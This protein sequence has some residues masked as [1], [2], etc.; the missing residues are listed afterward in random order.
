MPPY[1]L[2][3]VPQ[4]N[5][6]Y[7]NQWHEAA[8]MVLRRLMETLIIELYSR[9]GWRRDIQDTDTN[10]FLPLK[11]LINKLNGDAR[12][13]MQKRTIE[14]L[15]KVKELGDTAAHDFKIRIRKSDLDKIQSAVR[16]TC[17]RLIFTIGE[18]APTA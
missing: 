8:A 7:E 4:I 1:I 6:S 15:N 11:A 10:E 16:L 17:E 9:R 5:G 14:G 12:L 18:T 2:R 13:H 3:L